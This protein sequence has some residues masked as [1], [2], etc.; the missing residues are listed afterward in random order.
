MFNK[1]RFIEDCVRGVA[2]GHEA[3]RELMAEA[4]SDRAGILAEFGAPEHAG[5]TPIFRSPA[6]TVINFVWAPC[7]CL[8]PHNHQM[9]SVVGIYAGREDNIF[10][11]RTGPTIAATG[12]RSL[13]GGDVA[14]L[15]SDVIH[16]VLNPIGKMTCAIHVYG[17]DFF[18]PPTPR[19]EWDHETLS[20]RPWNVE[21]VKSLFR[22]AEARF[23]AS[24][25]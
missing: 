16:S 18:A 25:G 1:D 10:W 2:E 3:I 22:E 7:M 6:L 8:M 20:E 24:T 19:S 4:V 15:D 9:F 5:L 12:A 14:T 13:G 23:G 21:R 17:G 11:Q